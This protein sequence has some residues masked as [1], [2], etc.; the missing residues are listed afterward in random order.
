[1]KGFISSSVALLS[2]V[3]PL[4]LYLRDH[5]LPRSGSSPTAVTCYSV[6][7]SRSHGEQV[8]ERVL[9]CSGSA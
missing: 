8:G 1:M 2:L 5:F 6:L 4:C 3:F 7:D 9:Y